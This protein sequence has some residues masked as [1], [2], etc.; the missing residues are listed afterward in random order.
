MK[1]P[2]PVRG[3]LLARIFR[4]LRPGAWIAVATLL[5]VPPAPTFAASIASAK[6]SANITMPGPPPYGRS[7]TVRYA[8]VVQSRGFQQA[9][10]HN[11]NS[12]AR[13]VMPNPVI[14]ENISGNKV[15]TS[16]RK[17]TSRSPNPR[18]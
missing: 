6:G 9:N 7:S 5:A 10:R 16:N 8:S 2:F 15:M 18:E 12:K 13:R 14:A 3:A 17:V 4:P 11:P 1:S